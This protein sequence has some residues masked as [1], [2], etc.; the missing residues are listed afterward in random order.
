MQSFLRLITNGNIG[1]LI[2]K[3]KKMPE[4]VDKKCVLLL[5]T[6]ND[7]LDIAAASEEEML[8][9]RV[10]YEGTGLGLSIVKR[11]IVKYGVDR[12]SESGCGATVTLSLPKE[13]S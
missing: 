8:K 4:R 13:K 2:P 1:E 3:Q 6:V 10:M 5:A 9:Q 11:V 7:L 12:K